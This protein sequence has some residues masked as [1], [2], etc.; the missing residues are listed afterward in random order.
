MKRQAR[1]LL[2]VSSSKPCVQGE[3]CR[4]LGQG[5]H[6]SCANNGSENHY[7]FSA[8]RVSRVLAIQCV[9]PYECPKYKS[10][11]STYAVGL[12]R[13]SEAYLYLCVPRPWCGVLFANCSSTSVCNSLKLSLL[14]GGSM[15]VVASFHPPPASFL[16]SWN[17]P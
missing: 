2:S 12:T 14:T 15:Q 4:L 11:Y 6:L 9:D 8:Q 7:L 13:L 17:H 16:K 1:K 5:N 10:Y 3:N